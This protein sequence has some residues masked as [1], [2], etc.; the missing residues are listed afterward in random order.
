[1]SPLALFSATTCTLDR[2]RYRSAGGAEMER[3]R[4]MRA[5]ERAVLL[6]AT[7]LAGCAMAAAQ[8]RIDSGL[9]EAATGSDPSVRAFKGIPYAAPPV[10]DLRWK[11][12]HP[13]ARW[14]GVR[15]ATEFG[16]R[17]MQGPIYS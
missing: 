1:M 8:V 11:A 15:Q 2:R 9:V 16:P 4:R 6:L 3:R 17:P 14:K 12:P 10:G 13:V 7:M 5:I